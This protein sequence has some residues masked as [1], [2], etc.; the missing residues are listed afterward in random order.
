MYTH[1]ETFDQHMFIQRADNEWTKLDILLEEI[2]PSTASNTKIFKWDI[3]GLCETHLL[4]TYTEIL[5]NAHHFFNCG[6]PEGHK[7][8]GVGF[9]VHNL[10]AS[11]ITAF[12]GISDRVAFIKLKGKHN[13]I[14]I[15]Q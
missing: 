14:T 6:P 4:G 8:H 10:H 13:N 11:A 5:R 7:E 3:I 2:Y 15:I 1:S 9:I 12:K